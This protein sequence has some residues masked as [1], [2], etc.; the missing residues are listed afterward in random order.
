MSEHGATEWRVTGRPM[1]RIGLL[2]LPAID[3]PDLSSSNVPT[4]VEWLG[5]ARE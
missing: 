3:D 4:W 5:R 1:V 2:R